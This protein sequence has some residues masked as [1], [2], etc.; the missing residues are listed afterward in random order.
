VNRPIRRVGVFVAIL[1]LAVVLN[2]NWVQVIKADH[3]KDNSA[4]RR[5]VLDEY[6]R[7]R[8]SIVLQGSGTPVAESIPTK[9][10]LMYLRK[11]S[12]GPVYAAV[13]GFNS[14]YYGNTAIEAAEDGVLAGTDDRLFVQRLTN[15]LT[16]RDTRGGNVLLT[17]NKQ[18]Q[19]AAYQA[20]GPRRGAV[21]ALDPATGA[22]LAAVSTPSFDPNT[23]SSHSAEKIQAAYKRYNADPQNPLLNRVFNVTYP[24][25]SVFK[26]VVASAALKNGRTPQTRV[27]APN[28]LTLPNTRTQLR[29]FGGEQCAD[30]KTDTLIHALTISCN[31]AFAQLGM[32]LG[33]DTLKR[34]AAL[35]GI[36]DSGFGVPL[37]VAASSVGPVV[38]EPSL[39]QS[40]I[41]QRD[42]RVTPLQAAML[43]AAVANDGK[44]MKPYL[45]AEEQ[46]P[47][48]AVLS[49]PDPQLL[50][51]VMNP[52]QADQLTSMMVEVVNRGS[53]TAA[54]IPG[55][56][57]AGKTGTADN[58]P[59]NSDGVYLNPPHAWFSGFAPADNPKIAVA[60]II[61]NGGVRGSETTGG[62]EAAPVAQAVMKAYLAAIGVK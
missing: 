50:N 27:P 19:A 15:L 43:S 55:I 30:G 3:Y 61:E 37:G 5:T 47:N 12:G 52:T 24:P 11:Y 33:A 20:M 53:G 21:V 16:G 36:D 34:E 6:K 62:L 14:L 56:Q 57:V 2:L 54:Q 59:Q 42:V 51:Q 29:N 48:L 4:N 1:L 13:T 32:D 58:G 44:L 8:G 41:G 40:S 49:H 7:Q 60:V 31:T 26:V 39:A 28:T 23:L 10:A 25:G 17:V 35:F 45:I 9:D 38:D 18:A 22:I 46:A